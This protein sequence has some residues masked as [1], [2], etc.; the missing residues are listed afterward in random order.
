MLL[1]KQAIQKIPLWIIS[2]Y[3]LERIGS[4]KVIFCPSKKFAD[5]N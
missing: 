1:A 5:L 4:K 2:S 3:I